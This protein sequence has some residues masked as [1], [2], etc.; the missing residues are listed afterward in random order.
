[1]FCDLPDFLDGSA[2]EPIEPEVCPPTRD[3]RAGVALSNGVASG[4]VVM[5][6]HAGHSVSMAS[7]RILVGR[8]LDPGWSHQLGS[9]S[10]LVV[11]QGGVL[12]HAAV[13]ARELGIPA[14]ACPGAVA[15]LKDAGRIEVDG[16]RGRVSWLPTDGSEQ[17]SD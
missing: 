8:A 3:H 14:V 13:V 11:E 12:S 2:E 15:F 1:M 4:P 17:G 10:G 9:A 7:S 6:D 5:M 16:D